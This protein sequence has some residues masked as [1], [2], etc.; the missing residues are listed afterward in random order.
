M[1][2]CLQE[3]AAWRGGGSKAGQAGHFCGC[4][5]F[6][7]G[8]FQ[9]V[10]QYPT[11]WFLWAPCESLLQRPLVR[12]GWQCDDTLESLKEAFQGAQG[13]S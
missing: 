11:I 12:E 5:H 6:I 9:E 8:Y 10:H 7:S 13:Q 4:P 2:L 1:K 3:G